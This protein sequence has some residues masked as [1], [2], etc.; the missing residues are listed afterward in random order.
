MR[1]MRRIMLVLPVLWLVACSSGGDSR[2]A[3][4]PTDTPV[5]EATG[6]ATSVPVEPTNTFVLAAAATSTQRP[7]PRPQAQLK[8]LQVQCL[9]TAGY[10]RADG[11]ITN[12]GTSLL[13]FLQPSVV[14]RDA[15]GSV[16]G[17]GTGWVN[18]NE[19]SPGQETPFLAQTLSPIG[20]FN[21][22]SVQF[23]G[24]LGRYDIAGIAEGR[25]PQAA[26]SIPLIDGR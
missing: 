7:T 4:A 22:C 15:S 3:Q 5:L 6:T 21:G 16:V 2:G 11:V 25:L 13:S 24:I 23:Q 26:Q 1:V 17:S 8:L 10:G 19:L 18:V 9:S 12:T 14:F 20:P